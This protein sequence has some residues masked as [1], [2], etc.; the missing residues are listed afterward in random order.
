MI[1]NGDYMNATSKSK[2]FIRFAFWGFFSMCFLFVQTF[3]YHIYYKGKYKLKKSKTQLFIFIVFTIV[4]FNI[5]C[6]V[7][8]WKQAKEI[9]PKIYRI[10]QYPVDNSAIE[11]KS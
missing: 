7:H 5:V 4:T 9:L 11:I 3:F 8:F 2:G 1:E 10:S 6:L